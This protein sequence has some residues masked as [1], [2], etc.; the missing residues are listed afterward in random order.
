MVNIGTGELVVIFVI[1]A[2]LAVTAFA[3]LLLVV[4]RSPSPVPP[5]STDHTG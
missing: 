2:I 4:R 5:P 3:I 1:L